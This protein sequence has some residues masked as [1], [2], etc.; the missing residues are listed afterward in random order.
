MIVCTPVRVYA[1]EC[2]CKGVQACGSVYA[3]LQ[4]HG[5]VW[6]CDSACVLDSL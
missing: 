4:I 6:M 5:F 3:G 1:F 2:A